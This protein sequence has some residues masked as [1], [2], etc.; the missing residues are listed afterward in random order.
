MDLDTI[1]E[2]IGLLV[3]V[4]WIW[5][6]I[7][8]WRS[9]VREHP[10]LQYAPANRV[11]A[12]RWAT[13]PPEV[14]LHK[15]DTAEFSRL[16]LPDARSTAQVVALVAGCALM[17]LGAYMAFDALVLSPDRRNPFDA[18]VLPA[19]VLLFGGAMLDYDSRLVAIDLRQDRAVFVLRYG[20]FLTRNIT[21]KPGR[22]RRFSGKV[23]SVLTQDRDQRRPFFFVRALRLLLAR[24]FVTICDPSQGTWV[25]G[26]LEHW[27]TTARLEQSNAR[28]AGA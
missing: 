5:Q 1:L 3:L 10:P 15:L 7:Q 4:L 18:L 6:R 23:Q 11:E 27:R 26:G 8:D 9:F 28:R 12:W 14:A 17:L 2:G 20:V 25:V 19:L 22:V 24:E 16:T 21:M 13:P